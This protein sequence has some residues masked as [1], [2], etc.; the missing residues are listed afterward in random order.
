MFTIGL[1]KELYIVVAFDGA[2]LEVFQGDDSHRIHVSQIDK[3]E[4][5]MDRK[6]KQ[7]FEVKTFMGGSV[8]VPIDPAIAGRV[9]ELVASVQSA[10]A[11][12]E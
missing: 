11:W 6:G 10:L 4:V 7:T 2:V 9:T 1:N 5:V 12:P 8:Q 3:I